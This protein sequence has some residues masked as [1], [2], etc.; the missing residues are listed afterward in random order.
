MAEDTG[1]T[2]GSLVASIQ[3]AQM[4]VGSAITGGAG[5]VAANDNGS[6]PILEDL[7]SIGKENERNTQ[8]FMDTL[9]QMFQKRKKRCS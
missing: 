1:K 9:R 5:A 6:I 2:R 7:R 8:G 3:S 4:A